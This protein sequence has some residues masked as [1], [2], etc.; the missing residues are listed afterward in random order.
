MLQNQWSLLV[1]KSVHYRLSVWIRK[2]LAGQPANQENSMQTAPPH[3]LLAEL[4]KQELER[5]K[6][7]VKQLEYLIHKRRSKPFR[8]HHISFH[9]LQHWNTS[10]SPEDQH[11]GLRSCS[12]TCGGEKGSTFH[13][14]AR[15]IGRIISG[16]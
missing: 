6:M 12:Y 16:T 15:L 9:T 14:P 11:L 4:R 2:H 7:R 13:H 1:T 3:C 8:S 5:E 10:F